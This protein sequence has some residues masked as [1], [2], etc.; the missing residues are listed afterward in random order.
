MLGYATLAA[1]EHRVGRAC[2]RG[3]GGEGAM[4]AII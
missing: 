1:D 3:S 4:L 2:G